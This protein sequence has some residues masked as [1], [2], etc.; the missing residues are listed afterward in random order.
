MTL[1]GGDN[2]PFRAI[3]ARSELVRRVR[4][5]LKGSGLDI[6][7][8]KNELA[9]S[10]P[11]HPD[12]GRIYITYAKE[13]VSH[14]CMLWEYLGYLDDSDGD[15]STAEPRVNTETIINMLTEQ[16]GDPQ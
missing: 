11:G 3:R 15:G 16:D 6:R 1:A 9:I 7:E 2:D 10:S 13:E 8:L 14:G 5:R 4:A 12:K